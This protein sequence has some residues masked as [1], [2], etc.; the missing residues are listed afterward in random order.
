MMHK[1]GLLIGGIIVAVIMVGSMVLVRVHFVDAAQKLLSDMTNMGVVMEDIELRYSP[2]P[3]LR[4]TNLRVHTGMDT[5][6]IPQLEISR[7]SPVCSAVR[8]SC[9][10]W[11]CRTRT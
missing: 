10:M 9:V 3:S 7:I 4:V 2:L 8:L 6:H 1:K 11:S 5:V